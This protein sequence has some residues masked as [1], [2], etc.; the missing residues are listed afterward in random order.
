MGLQ[1]VPAWVEIRSLDKS[2]RIFLKFHA[3]LLLAKAWTFILYKAPTRQQHYLYLI[4]FSQEHGLVAS[5]ID[6]KIL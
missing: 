2:L 4:S 6:L 5:D 1:C 3:I